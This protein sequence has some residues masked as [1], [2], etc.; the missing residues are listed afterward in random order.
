MLV[1]GTSLTLCKDLSCPAHCCRL[2]FLLC[3]WLSPCS[4]S[5]EGRASPL[6]FL[7]SLPLSASAS[8]KLPHAKT[9]LA[10]ALTAGAGSLAGISSPFHHCCRQSLHPILVAREAQQAPN[11]LCPAL[12]QRPQGLSTGRGGLITQ[13]PT[14]KGGTCLSAKR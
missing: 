2:L 1:E 14:Q 7:F 8:C 9:V 6:A 5:A 4:Y 12:D 10:S 11:P 13:K 3:L